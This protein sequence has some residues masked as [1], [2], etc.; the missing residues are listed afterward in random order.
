MGGPQPAK[1]CPNWGDAQIECGTPNW[2]KVKVAGR[3][4]IDPQAT[5]PEQPAACPDL[6][7]LARFC[8]LVR[9]V[10]HRSLQRRHVVRAIPAHA[11]PDTSTKDESVAVLRPAP[12]VSYVNQQTSIEPVLAA[13]EM[14]RKGRAIRACSVHVWPIDV[15]HRNN[16]TVD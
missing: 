13:P 6:E 3:I 1:R 2:P 15:R 9:D 14:G 16:A 11:E 5:V 10:E 7:E 12:T 8:E 4:R